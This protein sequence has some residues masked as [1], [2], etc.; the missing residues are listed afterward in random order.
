[1]ISQ[2]TLVITSRLIA[3]NDPSNYPAGKSR[4][5]P[6]SVIIFAVIMSGSG[7]FL[8][9]QS[10]LVLINGLKQ[11]PHIDIDTF[12]L[13]T[14]GCVIGVQTVMFFYCSAVANRGGPGSASVRAIAADHFNDVCANLVGGIPA[15]I[16]GRNP[17][18]WFLDPTGAIV[19]S[20]YIALRWVFA[21]KEQI[22]Y[23]VGKSADPV[24]LGQLTYMAT[25]HDSR[26]KIET[27]LAYHIGLNYQVELHIVL[28]R[29][30]SLGEAHD[31][32][33]SLERTIERLDWV[34]MAFVH[35]D[36]ELFHNPEHKLRGYKYV[37]NAVDV[38]LHK[39]RGD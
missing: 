38:A 39:K 18:L 30:M 13:I 11:H 37:Q 14:L 6:L 1:L 12:T 16:A 2:G 7:L 20:L 29:E 27:V 36:F 32:A 9:Y 25:I 10:L 24:K 31:I 35:A 8:L 15:I 28:P 5:E 33:E 19:L 17:T 26:I 21:I 34:E 23:I 3:R 4:L 22:P